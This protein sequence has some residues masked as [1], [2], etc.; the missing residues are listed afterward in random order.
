M[1]KA[2][3]EKLKCL[4][5]FNLEMFVK[6]KELPY[7]WRWSI[8]IVN[9]GRVFAIKLGTWLVFEEDA[10]RLAKEKKTH[11]RKLNLNNL[12]SDGV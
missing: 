12:R 9:R 6:L 11:K 4:L 3:F 5:Q 10:R 8:E 7:S 2:A 1:D